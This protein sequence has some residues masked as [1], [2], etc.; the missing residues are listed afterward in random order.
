METTTTTTTTTT[1]P[2]TA[3]AIPTAATLGYAGEAAGDVLPASARPR[4]LAVLN[5]IAVSVAFLPLHMGGAAVE[6][7]T[8]YAGL[9]MR[10][11]GRPGASETWEAMITGPYLLAIPL[12]AWTFRLAVAPRPHRAERAIAWSLSLVSLVMTL[13]SVAYCASLGHRRFV[14]PIALTMGVLG[15]G[16]ACLAMLRPLRRAW[17]AALLAMTTAW[18]ASTTLVTLVVVSHQPWQTGG[19]VGA[20]VVVAQVVVMIVCAV[21]WRGLTRGAST[22][23]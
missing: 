11:R 15:V 20:L 9:L 5:L 3:A 10:L 17:P 8:K 14:L 2:T 4:A 12:A 16:I 19:V 1:T 7:I 22:S 18:A 21:R 23:G 6:S 13:L